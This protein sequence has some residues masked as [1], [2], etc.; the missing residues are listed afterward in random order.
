M[1]AKL[2]IEEM[3]TLAKN[4]DGRCLSNEYINDRTKLTWMCSEGHKWNGSPFCIKSGTWCPV[5]AKKVRANTKMSKTF[6]KVKE[7]AKERGGECLSNAY[8]KNHSKL[9]FRCKYGHEWETGPGQIKNHHWCPICSAKIRGE[10]S[11]KY[12]I[13]DIC[14]TM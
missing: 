13:D 7:I 6:Q 8:E 14:L 3:H 5:C 2:T 12:T 9:R 4:R 10:K 1:P 11:R